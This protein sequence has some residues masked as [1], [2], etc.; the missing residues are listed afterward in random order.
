MTKKQN[1]LAF[2]YDLSKIKINIY[3]RLVVGYDAPVTKSNGGRL[4]L[5]QILLTIKDII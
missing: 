3:G 4:N 2:M 5:G 1:I